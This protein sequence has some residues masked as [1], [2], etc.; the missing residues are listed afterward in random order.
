MVRKKMRSGP[1]THELLCYAGD[2]LAEQMRIPVCD[3][4]YIKKTFHNGQYWTIEAK[5]EQLIDGRWIAV[6]SKHFKMHIASGA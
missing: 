1:S 6:D 3:L 4:R 5:W 2:K